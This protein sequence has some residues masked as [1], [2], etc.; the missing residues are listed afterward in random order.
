M[1][2]ARLLRVLAALRAAGGMLRASG[3]CQSSA[4]I[5]GVAGAS[6]TLI[7]A[8]TGPEPL[9]S[10]GA[11]ASL[12]AALQD[13]LG[14]GP[15]FDAHRDGVPSIEPDIANPR[16]PRWPAL[17][18]A[19]QAEGI[20][21]LFAFPLRIGAARLGA[22]TLHQLRSGP[23]STEQHLDALVM[24]DV[25]VNS[26]LDMQGRA[27]GWALGADLE[28]LAAHRAEV[29]QASGMLSAQLGVSVTEAMVRLRAH[30]FAH[31][32]PL[33]DVAA[34]VV[35]GRLRLPSE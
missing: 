25:I 19:A 5:I 7:A 27:A 3:L 4:Q 34:D 2:S 11:L 24:A 29:H 13:T 16:R 8:R 6:I 31:G 35:S 22:L 18:S 28:M 12:A 33:A 20:A 1:D 32:R 10:S 26:V 14:E 17:G 21:A 30:A 23:L 9:C 15:T